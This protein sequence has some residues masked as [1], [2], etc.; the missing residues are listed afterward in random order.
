MADG[1]SSPSA[2]LHVGAIAHQFPDDRNRQRITAPS[3]PKAN[4]PQRAASTKTTCTIMQGRNLKA[5]GNNMR[6]KSEPPQRPAGDANSW[7]Q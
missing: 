4:Q 7:Y 1:F 5:A 2:I 3:P 6:R